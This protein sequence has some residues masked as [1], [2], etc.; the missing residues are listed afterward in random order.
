MSKGFTLI[1]LLIVM[2]IIGI[3]ATIGLVNFSTA[4][5]KA[6][7]AKRKTDLETVA[8]SLEA[9]V[10]DHRGYP[11][12][13]AGRIVCIPPAT[14]CDWGSEFSDGNGTIYTAKLP[15]DTSAPNRVYYYDSG[16][17]TYTLYASLENENDPA[18][19]ESI[20]QTCGTGVTCNYKITSSNTQ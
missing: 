12:S 10:N 19:D 14:T 13:N 20:V 1:E 7:D 9:Y 4:R 15:T 5:L 8:K 2:V 11:V 17:T 16:G 18:I 6:R 3:L